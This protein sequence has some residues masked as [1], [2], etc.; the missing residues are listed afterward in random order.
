MT[1]EERFQLSDLP[2]WF[3]IQKYDAC[4][5]FGIGDWYNNLMHRALRRSMYEKHRDFYWTE[6]NH[7]VEYWLQNPIA[8]VRKLEEGEGFVKNVYKSQ[9]RDQTAVELLN[10][11][12]NMKIYGDVGTVYRDAADV[13]YEDMF[14]ESKND[15][16]ARN[17]Y[18]VLDIPAWKMMTD[19]GI[20][21]S[22][23][24]TV[25]VDLFSSEKKLVDDFKKW[26][27]VTRA[28]LNVPNLG[29]RFDKSDYERWHKNRVL[30][31]LDLTLWAKVK[32]HRLTNQIMG[33]ALFPDE[34]SVSLAERV[35]KTVAPDALSACSTPYL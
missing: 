12:W 29:K 31:Y 25:T 3:D 34:Y 21:L 15:E 22:G 6:L 24:V 10:G 35:R 19:I 17:A 9:V 5:S 20:D 33:V 16:A 8:P 27:R 4:A 32:G 2:S 18:D 13:L 7:S 30:A 23:E 28:A 14:G 26:L 1:I 11:D